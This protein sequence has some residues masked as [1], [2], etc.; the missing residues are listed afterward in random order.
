MEHLQMD[1]NNWLWILMFSVAVLTVRFFQC[2]LSVK[3]H[4][5]LETGSMKQ[6]DIK[7]HQYISVGKTNS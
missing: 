7:P 4:P 5:L 6:P 2:S 3:I 1:P